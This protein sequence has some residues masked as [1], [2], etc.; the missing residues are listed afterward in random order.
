MG[1]RAGKYLHQIMMRDRN[2]S[3]RDVHGNESEEYVGVVPTASVDLIVGC[4]VADLFP[5]K[6]LCCILKD[7]AGA[8]G[9]V[10]YLPICFTGS[11]RILS[12][13][14][15]ENCTQSLSRNTF[16]DKSH[17]YNEIAKRYDQVQDSSVVAHINN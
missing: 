8:S 14:S 17:A 9:S 16:D 6:A 12:R 5:P 11:T 3:G 13:R 2:E 1:E 4:C 10:V 7:L 15:D